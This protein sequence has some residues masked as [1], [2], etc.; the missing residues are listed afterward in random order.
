MIAGPLGNAVKQKNPSSRS[1]AVGYVADTEF[2]PLPVIQPP[3]I[4]TRTPVL[5]SALFN[6]G[7]FGE[8]RCPGC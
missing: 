3:P 6:V 4:A 5:V 2:A 8:I 7:G 1:A